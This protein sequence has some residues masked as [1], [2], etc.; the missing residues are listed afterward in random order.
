[1]PVKR[2]PGSNKNVP[3]FSHEF[4]IQNHPDI[5]S[6]FAMLFV[7]G[8]IFQVKYHLILLLIFI[9]SFI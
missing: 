5:V 2:R 3:I 6:C 4:F 8:L 1:M 9:T 7:V